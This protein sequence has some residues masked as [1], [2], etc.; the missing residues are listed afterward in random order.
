MAV[1][2]IVGGQGG[3]EGKGKI[4]QYLSMKNNYDLVLRVSVPQAG[5]SIIY[6]GEKVGLATL[7]CGFINENSEIFI[8][9]GSF[10]SVSRLEE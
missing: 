1:D 8:G 10:I 4:A 6:N 5:H 7:P 2:V 3:D 9:R